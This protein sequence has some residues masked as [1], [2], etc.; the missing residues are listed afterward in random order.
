[1][2]IKERLGFPSPPS[3]L[4]FVESLTYLAAGVF[5]A[6]QRSISRGAYLSAAIFHRTQGGIFREAYFKSL[7]PR[8]IPIYLTLIGICCTSPSQSQ[9]A[10]SPGADFPHRSVPNRGGNSR[11]DTFNHKENQVK[12]S[13]QS[14]YTSDVSA[15]DGGPILRSP[16]SACPPWRGLPSSKNETASL[17]AF[18]RS[19]DPLHWESV[20]SKVEASD[21]RHR[22]S[23]IKLN[24]GLVDNDQDM[25]AGE[26]IADSQPAPFPVLS[27]QIYSGREAYSRS[28][29]AQS[30]ASCVLSLESKKSAPF[31][32]L[33]SIDQTVSSLLGASRSDA[34][35]YRALVRRGGSVSGHPTTLPSSIIETASLRSSTRSDDPQH[36]TTPPSP[37][38]VI[39]GRVTEY[40]SRDQLRLLVYP[41]YFFD[42]PKAPGANLL[43]LPLKLGNLMEGAYPKSRSFQYNLSTSHEPQWISLSLGESVPFINRYRIDPGDTVQVFLNLE[44]NS[45]VFAGPAAVKFKLQ[46]D[47]SRL[48]EEFQVR[49]PPVLWTENPDQVL[50]DSTYAAQYQEAQ[51]TAGPLLSFKARNQEA[52]NELGNR[53]LYESDGLLY[54]S[55]A[56]IDSY[57]EELPQQFLDFFKREVELREWRKYLLAIN[58]HLLYAKREKENS[59]FFSAVVSLAEIQIGNLQ[60]VLAQEVSPFS[61]EM[62][63]LL[64]VQS[65]IKAGIANISRYLHDPVSDPYWNRKMLVRLFYKSYDL[66]P[67]APQYLNQQLSQL[68]ESSHKDW[69]QVLLDLKGTGKKVS[70]FEFFDRSGALISFEDVAEGELILLEF[71]IT[72]CKA[73][74][75]FN[76]NTLTKV[77]EEFGKNSPIQVITVSADFTEELWKSSLESGK[78]TQEEFVNLYTGSLNRKHP[79]LLQYGISSFPNRILL[80][81]EGRIIQASQVPFLAEE[82]IPLLKT[83]LTNPQSKSQS[84]L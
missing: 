4:R 53:D 32:V 20:Q 72:G 10:D 7:V 70:G 59:A 11:S 74:L 25:G 23:E 73:C 31:P 68:E 16:V 60:S 52:L 76:E 64:D 77:K 2:A 45:L 33:A 82:L 21:I 24:F 81:G 66:I 19:D 58:S 49:I 13:K 15:I 79:F 80:D 22:T 75:A 6:A 39:W 30:L 69:L 9:V 44:S 55:W 26:G 46:Q 47:L 27:N 51:S 43:F 8:T 83:Y 57:K 40:G 3:A 61:A 14:V 42:S 28:A 41:E 12:A 38:A 78:Y 48:E 62:M 37:D 50:I 36:P 34:S 54:Q 56:L 63:D 5:H 35:Q 1:M 67:E 71:W 29:E 65:R 17:R 18:A 84:I